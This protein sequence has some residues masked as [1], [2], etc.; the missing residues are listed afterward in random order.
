MENFSENPLSCPIH[1]YARSPCPGRLW[2]RWRRPTPAA[3]SISFGAAPPAS[4]ATGAKSNISAVVSN[5][6]TNAGVSLEHQLQQFRV[7]FHL[8]CELGERRIGHLHRAEFD[9]IACRR[10][11]HRQGGCRYNQVCFCVR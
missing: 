1:L 6:S 5:D 3:I 11:H 2:W 4:L 10:H 9:S 7:W 8:F